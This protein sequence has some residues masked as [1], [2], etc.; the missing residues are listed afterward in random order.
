MIT[1]KAYCVSFGGEYCVLAWAETPNKAKALCL[2][3]YVGAEDEPYTCL[4]VRRV[5]HMDG[6]PDAPKEPC[7][8]DGH[9]GRPNESALV[10]RSFIHR[11]RTCGGYI[12]N[13]SEDPCEAPEGITAFELEVAH[14]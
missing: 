14:A 10:D 7:V 1:L 9:G 8:M 3:Y 5:R 13:C 12:E 2:G 4:R 11:C 6:H